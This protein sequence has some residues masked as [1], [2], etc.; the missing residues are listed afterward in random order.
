MRVIPAEA[1]IGCG[2]EALRHPIVAIGISETGAI[3]LP[4]CRTCWENPEHRKVGIKG[5]FFTRAQERVALAH[6]GSSQIGG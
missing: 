2:A 5:H 6:A 1:C 4:V 3:A